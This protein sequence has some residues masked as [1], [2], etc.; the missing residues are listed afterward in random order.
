MFQV[1]VRTPHEAT[2]IERER[3]VDLVVSGGGLT[4][5][6]VRAGIPR[7]EAL[8]F[9]TVGQRVVGVAALKV[10]KAS[11]REGLARRSTAGV[12]P[13]RFPL[14]LGYVAV[15]PG[16]RRRGLGSFL[17]AEIAI[18]ARGR[19][20]LATTGAD[21][22]RDVILPKLAFR[23]AGSSWQGQTEP[24]TLMLREPMA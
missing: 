17:C 15:D 12:P 23:P 2:E 8:V 6:A 18:L 20:L 16:W 9:C 5:Q 4:E 13:A 3:L 11:Y 1:Y 7:A 19:G 21:I 14:E 22:M 10:P 24:L